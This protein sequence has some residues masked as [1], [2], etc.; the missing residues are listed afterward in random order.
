[1]CVPLLLVIGVVHQP[2]HSLVC[3]CHPSR[4]TLSQ[5]VDMFF[6]GDACEVPPPLLATKGTV[7]PSTA[8]PASATD[9]PPT[10]ASG[11]RS[12]LRSRLAE[13]AI[14]LETPKE[15]ERREQQEAELLRMRKPPGTGFS[16]QCLQQGL[17]VL[18]AEVRHQRTAAF[19]KSFAE[20]LRAYRKVCVSP[21][22]V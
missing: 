15:R 10:S 7:D 4:V 2:R 19:E 16:T 6:L 18:R 9:S 3:P 21:H 5:V 8:S 11:K 17:R 14:A 1:M 13:R 12:T 20:R 22:L